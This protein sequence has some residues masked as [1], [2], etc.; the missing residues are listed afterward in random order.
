MDVCSL[1]CEA[2]AGP[3]DVGAQD[4]STS[5]ATHTAEDDVD[6][7]AAER[8]VERRLREA[9]LVVPDRLLSREEAWGLAHASE[10]G[11]AVDGEMV[12]GKA[13]YNLF[14]LTG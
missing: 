11:V 1:C 14:L 7:D 12:G 9:G 13:W 2:E 8:A 10:Q 4:A 6:M 3:S 5:G